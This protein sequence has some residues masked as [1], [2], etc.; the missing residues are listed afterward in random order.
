MQALYTASLVSHDRL[1][2]AGKVILVCVAQGTLQ[3]CPRPFEHSEFDLVLYP[4][5][6]PMSKRTVATHDLRRDRICP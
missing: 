6:T 3:H 2:G 1:P 4:K 5:R